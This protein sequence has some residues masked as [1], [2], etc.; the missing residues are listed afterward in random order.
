MITINYKLVGTGWAECEITDGTKSV[1]T[2]ASYLSDA[3]RSL[4]EAVFEIT[5]HDIQESRAKFDEEPGEFRFIFKKENEFIKISI[6]KFDDLW[7]DESDENGKLIFET[8]CSAKD[9]KQSM[10]ACLDNILKE[11][12]LEEY[13]EKWALC[14]FPE[15]VYQKLKQ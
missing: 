7:S 8:I 3:L 10:I 11:Y 4:A 12:S 13:A 6:L 14:D 9:L 1:L 2:S 5:S 15:D